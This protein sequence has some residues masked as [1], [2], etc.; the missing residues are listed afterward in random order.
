MKKT[1]L[2]EIGTEEMPPNS[3]V[4]LGDAFS[5]S[6]LQSMSAHQVE[7]GET[8]IFV[9]PRRLGFLVSDVEEK[10]PPQ[11]IEK[12][13]PKLS[14][15]YDS[16]GNLTK[17]AQGFLSSL[18]ITLED[19]E[20]EDCLIFKKTMPGKSLVDLLPDMLAKANQALPI[21]KRMSWSDKT[22][23][24]VRP[25]HWFVA[26]HGNQVLP[27]SFLDL[28]ANNITQ[29]H[30]FHHPQPQTLQNADEY[31]AKLQALHVIG[32]WQARKDTLLQHIKAQ[33][34]LLK[35]NAIIHEGTLCEV[36]GL[37]EWPVVYHGRFDSDF[38]EVP[39]ECLISSM[40]HHQRY[41]PVCDDSGKLMPYFIFAS[42]TDSENP[43]TVIQGNERVLAARLS[44]A[45]FFYHQDLK[46]PLENHL[47]ALKQVVFQDKLGSLGDK[48]DRLQ[49][50]I[51]FLSQTIH[52]DPKACIR[53]A[54]L[55]KCDLLSHMVYEF[56]ELQGIMGKYYAEAAKEAPSVAAAIEYHYYPR[57]ANDDLPPDAISQALS[58]AD[59]IDTLVG[60]FGIGMLPTGTKDPFAL[61]RT[62]LG[63]VRILIEKQIPLELNTLIAATLT[64]Y[65]VP[66]ATETASTLHL[67]I[68]E[69]LK[70]YWLDQGFSSEMIQAVLATQSQNLWDA[71]LRLLAL[72]DFLKQESALSLASANKRVHN[73]LK[74]QGESTLPSSCKPELFEVAAEHHLFEQLTQCKQSISPL[75]QDRKYQ[76]ALSMLASLREPIDTF[77]DQVMVMVDNASVR[78]NRLILL[79][80]LRKLFCEVADFAQL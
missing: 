65:K 20:K 71:Q 49:K 73:L 33:A 50:N 62:A 4:A 41:F 51:E 10:Q 72:M 8:Q 29:G 55:S 19:C 42:N 78:E 6:L 44:D 36:T 2:I 32:R 61:R 68:L 54:M 53:A 39:K 45:R 22:I 74:K 1:L 11:T 75:L 30:R 47:P 80:A 31:P 13:G 5:E 52:A 27:V 58:L 64:T 67:F 25:V 14:A 46:T 59:K 79:Q 34:A 21:A 7:H 28:P 26:M 60:I 9:T 16:A 40:Q 3:L 56:P 37:L 70:N 38:L 35:G 76:Q 15:C 43:E 48:V 66:L 69:R 17:A 63:I 77:F 24:F 57:F 12:K 23:A 18:S